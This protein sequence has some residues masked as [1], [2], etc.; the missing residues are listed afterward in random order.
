LTACS[1]AARLGGRRDAFERVPVVFLSR[2]KV[3]DVALG[4]LCGP[5]A[6]VIVEFSFFLFFRK[7]ENLSVEST[8]PP[9]DGV[10][11]AKFCKW[12]VGVAGV[13]L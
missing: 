7:E 12:T 6:R 13:E 3:T 8:G 5:S 10:Y 2:R 11:G 4:C 1:A 9:T